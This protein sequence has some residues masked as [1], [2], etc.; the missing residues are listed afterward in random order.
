MLHCHTHILCSITYAWWRPHLLR[1]GVY[2]TT[3]AIAPN[4]K[5]K[6]R[7]NGWLCRQCV[8][9]DM[10]F[11]VPNFCCCRMYKRHN[12]GEQLTVVESVIN[13][14]RREMAVDDIP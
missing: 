2:Q 14:L 9:A 5:C 12:Q 11:E 13:D 6:E 3:Q 1:S 8:A 7:D 4:A 10:S